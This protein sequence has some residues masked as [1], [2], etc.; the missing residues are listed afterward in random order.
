MTSQFL[1]H[2]IYDRYPLQPQSDTTD[3]QTIDIPLGEFRIGDYNSLAIGMQDNAGKNQIYAVRSTVSI[4]GRNVTSESKSVFPQTT[5]GFYGVA[6]TYTV[7][8]D[9]K[10]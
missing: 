2:Q 5:G 4:H 9:G 10:Q 3:W 7:V 1:L 8:R 6:F